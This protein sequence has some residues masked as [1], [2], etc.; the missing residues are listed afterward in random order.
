MKIRYGHVSNSSTSSFFG[1]G[2]WGEDI[3]K[4]RGTDITKVD[5]NNGIGLNTGLDIFC[6]WNE[7]TVAFYIDVE[8]MGMDETKNQFIA[9]V[10]ELVNAKF[11]LKEGRQVGFIEDS[12]Y[13]G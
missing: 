8:G 10:T 12:Y 4:V 13:N 6:N 9:R 1:V 3:A 11:E 2:V 5:T 7:D